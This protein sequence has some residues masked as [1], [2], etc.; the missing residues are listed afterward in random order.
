LVAAVVLAPSALGGPVV[1][2][3]WLVIIAV[4]EAE[5]VVVAYGMVGTGIIVPESF[6]E[7]LDLAMLCWIYQHEARISLDVT[8]GYTEPFSRLIWRYYQDLSTHSVTSLSYNYDM[9]VTTH[10]I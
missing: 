2:G 6:V 9:L 4:V 3:S 7:M 1:V 5:L 8:I 10:H